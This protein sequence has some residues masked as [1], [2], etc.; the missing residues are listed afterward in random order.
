[1]AISTERYPAVVT[2]NQDDEKRGRIKVACVGIT[3]S[4]DVELPNWIEPT[5]DWGFFVV[6]DI[7][8]QVE[9]EISTD[10]DLDE[11]RAQTSI[12]DSDMRWR[13]KRFY[14]SEAE[15]PTPIPDD[16]TGSYGKQRGFSTPVGHVLLFD[17]T[18]GG[19]KVYLTWSKE[20]DGDTSQLLFDTDGTI[21]FT[22]KGKATWHLKDNEIEVKLDGNGAG[23][24]VSGKDANAT[25]TLG[26]GAVSAAIAENLQTLWTQLKTQCDIFDAHTHTTGVGP[27]GPPVPLLLCPAWASNIVSGKL[28][29]PSG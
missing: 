21:K 27:S 8:E 16:F 4:E 15:K 25:T 9:I 19:T 22:N 13:A 24:K 12:A 20:P 14:S 3:G 11:I 17:D 1:M 6:P 28:K 26:N 5:F 18:D 23:F 2:N 7:D 10:S 29:F